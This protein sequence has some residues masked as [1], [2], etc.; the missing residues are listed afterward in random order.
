MPLVSVLMPVFNTVAYVGDA[1]ESIRQQS[2]GDFELIVLNDGSTDGSTEVLRSF[3]GQDARIRLIEQP[4]RGLIASRNRLLDEARGEFI[5]WM[6][7]DDLS[8]GERLERQV[9]AFAA[10]VNLACVGT[11]VRLI[12]PEGLPLGTEEYPQLDEQIRADQGLGTGFRF[13]S[14]MQRRAAALAAGSFRG[15]PLG[16][17]L[18][19][20]LRVAEHGGLSNVPEV[21]YVYR[22]HLLSTCTALGKNW[23]AYRAAILGLAEERRS[24]GTDKLQRGEP[25]ELPAI[26]SGEVRNF[27]PLVL[28][29]WANRAVTVGDR[30]RAYRYTVRAIRSAPL[31]E[32]GWRQL[33]KLMLRRA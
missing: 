27:I 15:F 33:A 32:A 29:D 23:P 2:F 14:T 4:N 1:I 7:S 19:F 16:E 25:I 28:L 10:D 18:D 9:R 6:D 21:L 11:N 24:L 26:A 30:P 12:D 22:Q 5:A 8:H 3:A 17:D 31:Q 13:A 20:L